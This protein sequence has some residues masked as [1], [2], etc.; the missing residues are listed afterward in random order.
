MGKTAAAECD[1]PPAFYFYPCS[2]FRG[3][4]SPFF[5]LRVRR[6]FSVVDSKKWHFFLAFQ[7]ESA[8]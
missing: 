2:L 7:Q 3:G 4:F 8:S 1:V 6:R 5:V